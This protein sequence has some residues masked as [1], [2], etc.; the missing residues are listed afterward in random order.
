MP[1]NRLLVASS[2]MRWCSPNSIGLGITMKPSAR[3]FTIVE[4][5]LAIW[6]GPSAGASC[7]CIPKVRAASSIL[8]TMFAI[9]CSP[10]AWGCQKCSHT[11]E[12]GDDIYEQLQA[13]GRAPGDNDVDLQPN[14]FS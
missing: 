5:A 2:T 12:P 13:L 10:Y 7:S 6:S 4:K 8:F 9:V 11:N 14:E 1:G 3:S